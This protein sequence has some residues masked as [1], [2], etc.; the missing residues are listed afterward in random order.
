[1]SEWIL[2]VKLEPVRKTQNFPSSGGLTPILSRVVPGSLSAILSPS[3]NRKHGDE[4]PSSPA[5]PTLGHS[6]SSSIA[7]RIAVVDM[8]RSDS[9]DDSDSSTV[10]DQ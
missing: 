5:T 4:A 1:M 10:E 3:T 8:F 7:E 2:F 6:R 9:D